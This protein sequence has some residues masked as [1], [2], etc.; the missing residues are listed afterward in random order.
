MS[1]ESKTLSKT[2]MN[3]DIENYYDIEKN[4]INDMLDEKWI[5]EFDR[6]EKDYS[7]FYKENIEVVALYNVYMNIDKEIEFIKSEKIYTD[8]PNSISKERLVGLLKS[9]KNMNMV[10]YSLNGVCKYNVK[11]DVDEISNY[12]RNP[13]SEGYLISLDSLDKIIFEPTITMFQD[14]NSIYVFY[15]KKKENTSSTNNK[16]KTTKRVRFNPILKKGT[17][18]RM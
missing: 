18:R 11:L 5:E 15:I 17:R 8:E 10:E 9:N 1:Q 13:H 3:I 16:N 14:M 6:L 4:N 12:I 7:S 2:D